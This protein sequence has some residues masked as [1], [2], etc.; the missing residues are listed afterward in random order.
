MYVFFHRA[1]A[2]RAYAYER[3]TLYEDTTS[4]PCGTTNNAKGR[5]VYNMV[6]SESKLPVTKS[7]GPC[8]KLQ[9]APRRHVPW[10]SQVLG[11]PIYLCGQRHRQRP[12][13]IKNLKKCSGPYE[14]VVAPTMAMPI[15]LLR[16]FAI[17]AAACLAVL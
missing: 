17:A 7:D 1:A 12:L 2:E 4:F 6:I 5:V 3:T 10:A 9:S 8:A 14:H 15:S 13:Q 11:N 16:Y